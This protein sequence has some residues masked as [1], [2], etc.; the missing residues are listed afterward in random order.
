VDVAPLVK[1][2]TRMPES[3]SMGIG[4]MLAYFR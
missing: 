1:W 4:Y 2:V 3:S